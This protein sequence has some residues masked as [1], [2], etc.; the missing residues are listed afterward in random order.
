MSSLKETIIKENKKLVHKSSIPSNMQHAVCK[1]VI[2]SYANQVPLHMILRDA[3]QNAVDAI[4]VSGREDGS[5]YIDTFSGDRGN[6]LTISDNGCGFTTDT[7]LKNFNS[8]FNSDKYDLQELNDYDQCKGIGM[9]I[10]SYNHTNLKYSTKGATGNFSFTFT[11]DDEGYP[12]LQKFFHEDGSEEIIIDLEDDQEYSEFLRNKETGTDTTFLGLFPEENIS[13]KIC[14]SIKRVVGGVK[15][16]SGTN[17]YW[18]I[19]RF[20]NTRYYKIPFETKCVV[21]HHEN[22]KVR[23][24]RIMGSQHYLNKKCISNGKKEYSHINQT[25]ETT[26]DFQ[27]EWYIME[28]GINNNAHFYPPFVALE[29]KN[30]LYL[31]F[32]PINTRKALLRSCGLGIASSRVVFILKIREKISVLNDR[33][34]IRINGEK[35]PIHE[36]CE[37]IGSDLPH[38][39]KIF[40]SQLIANSDVSECLE[41]KSFKKFLKQTYSNHT[42]GDKAV[43][44][45]SDHISS[46]KNAIDIKTKRFSKQKEGVNDNNSN[47]I[48]DIADYGNKARSPKRRKLKHIINSGKLPTLIED[49]SLS[50]DTWCSFQATSYELYYNPKWNTFKQYLKMHYFDSF[51]TEKAKEKALTEIL[52]KKVVEYIFKTIHF[53]MKLQDVTVKNQYLTDEDLTKQAWP[54]QAEVSAWKRSNSMK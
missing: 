11:K 30:E 52:L 46:T 16:S 45:S 1:R 15:K 38:E 42:N 47:K 23:V 12:G 6:K 19:V 32:A 10:T 31:N 26:L 5:I 41:S 44:K 9:K 54:S 14:E 3:Y 40:K 36:L 17:P 28:E 39:I 48:I 22:G 27:L 2:E 7:A 50:E 4:F 53:N 13:E 29:Y 51:D 24:E 25:S 20:L 43:I 8:V 35:L 21:G 49:T 37:T 18:G 33:N 34:D